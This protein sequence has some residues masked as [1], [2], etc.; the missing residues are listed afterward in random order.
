MFLLQ[1]LHLRVDFEPQF[2]QCPQSV[3]RTCYHLNDLHDTGICKNRVNGSA[4]DDHHRRVAVRQLY[5]TEHITATCSTYI[6][7]CSGKK[8]GVVLLLTLAFVA[9]A[10]HRKAKQIT[11]DV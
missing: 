6:I 1:G 4:I 10:A 3:T 11:C 7:G 9:C 8:W 5:Y 2:N